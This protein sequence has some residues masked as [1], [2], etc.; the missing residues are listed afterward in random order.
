LLI[1]KCIYPL[2]NEII[3][4]KD[5]RMNKIRFNNTTIYCRLDKHCMDSNMKVKQLVYKHNMDPN[6]LIL[7]SQVMNL[8]MIFCFFVISIMLIQL[9]FMQF[10]VFFSI[11]LINLQL[12]KN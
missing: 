1:I 6:N 11:L 5:Y 10:L 8:M 9:K 3:E 2:E 4:L 12:S 7:K